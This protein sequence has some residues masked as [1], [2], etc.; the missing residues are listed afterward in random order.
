[1]STPASVGF[2]KR[3][4]LRSV[5]RGI[6]HQHRHTTLVS[7]ATILMLSGVSAHAQQ[8]QDADQPAAS[9]GLAEIV[10][11]AQRRDESLQDVP[12]NISALSS[13]AL[14]NAAIFSL[15]DLT[16]L[17]PGLTSVDEGPS[18]RAGYQSLTLRGIRT[19]SP[20][21]G[22]AGEAYDPLTVNP[23]STY[24]GET[25]VFFQMPLED[26]ERVEVLRGP[27][28]T[29]Y[30][31][32][33]EAGTIRIVPKRPDFAAFS[34]EVDANGSWTEYAPGGNSSVHGVMNVPIT[35]QLAFR[36]VAGY[37]HLGGFIKA[38]DRFELEPNG[39][40]VP[41][42]PGNLTSGPVLAPIENGVNSS[43]QWFARGALRWQPIGP[44]DIQLDYV[45]LMTTA[46]DAQWGS[47]IYK[48]GL[49]ED[50]GGHW[51]N[52]PVL[53]RPGCDYCSTNFVAEPYS[54][55]TDLGSLVATFDVGLATIT[56]ASSYYD[57]SNYTVAD[58]TPGMINIGGTSFIVYYPYNFFP[59][60][61]N[62]QHTNDTDRSF[63]QELRMVSKEG[64]R[65]DYVVGL[66]FQDEKNNMGMVQTDPGVTE[67]L[68]YTGQ[69]SLAP[70][71][72]DDENYIIY[73]DT[74]FNDKA[75]F[76][77]LTFHAT[78]AWQVTGGTRFFRQSFLLDETQLLPIC[79]AICAQNLV[80]PT[81]L[82]ISHSYNVVNN[83]LWKLNTSYNL[84]ATTKLYATFSEGFRRGG[85]GG[86]PESGPY[87]SEPQYLTFNPEFLKN[88]EVGIKGSL[89]DH[90]VRYFA[91]AYLA[92]IYDFQL[93]ELSLSGIPGVYNGSD[94]RTQGVELQVDAAATDRLTLGLGYAYT[95][96]YVRES[97]NIL[98]Y[99]PYALIP[100]LGGTGE[101]SSVT[102]G[103]IS[104][105]ATLPGVPQNTL[106]ASGNYTIP[107][108]FRP[109]WTWML[110]MD[111][112]YR[113]SEQ[114]NISPTSV[115]N[116]TI[117]SAFIL[118][119]RV[120]L[121]TSQRWS[122]NLFANNITSA[123]AY[124]GSEFAQTIPYPYSLRNIS[125]PRTIGIGIRYAFR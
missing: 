18:D 11:S 24:W 60:T 93:N 118:N 6:L 12:Y 95:K 110:H 46:A 44:I 45:H 115:F 69:P 84:S 58:G 78:D 26:V 102:Y 119:A 86:L 74:T 96:A 68:A 4:A 66:Y 7:S 91:D 1:M 87:A 30:G 112:D 71:A 100:S 97:F 98:D 41:S 62:P 61:T 17:V 29:L 103:P 51:P 56:S 101:V 77:E 57:K 48:G 107:G 25:P 54:D 65:F 90:R 108:G 50:D 36:L 59:R 49:F 99:P 33:S 47:P 5:V 40:P 15:S 9:S 28:G 21:G 31:S 82:T 16:R 117:P 10:V 67:Y 89:F 120:T 13:D 121:T 122:Y 81:G 124:S 116:W 106:T 19:D 52:A 39:T 105:G 104:A 20:G 38:V 37:D 42:I 72:Y 23:I 75:I 22:L 53:L 92:N 64:G 32:G 83:H 88:Y 114:A 109:D 3:P 63:V 113:S 73:R 111:A 8:K 80:D 94:A 35:D 2:R 43:N 76:G 125:R 79:G 34:A 27:Q 123:T 55:K 14:Q 85:A 70:A